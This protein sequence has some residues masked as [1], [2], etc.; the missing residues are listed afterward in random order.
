[1]KE[2]DEIIYDAIQADNT[3]MEEIGGRVIS[4]CF[5]VS[6]TEKDNTPLPNII[7]TDDGFQNTDSTKDSVWEGSRDGVQA[8][9]EIAGR[10]RNEV[11]KI[12]RMVRKAVQSHIESMC[13]DGLE[14]PWLQSLT[15]DGV[16]WDWMKPCYYQRI[17][18]N[19]T[20]PNTYNDEQEE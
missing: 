12:V 18:Y 8:S 6:P 3:L 17:S 1:M 14:T 5:E 9:V 11:K 16:D 13:E 4:T 2:F 15:S 19:V 20:T 10:S 7:I